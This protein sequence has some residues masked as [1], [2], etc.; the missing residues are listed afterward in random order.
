LRETGEADLAIER[1]EM[2]FRLDPRTTRPAFHLT[3]M[4]IC[5]FWRRR[6]DQAAGV[7][8]ASLNELPTYAMTT[9]FLVACYAHTGNAAE[10]YIRKWNLKPRAEAHDRAFHR[11]A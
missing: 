10:T 7:L 9:W 8:E 6:F 4:G 2:S 11:L 3:C 1:F 5:H